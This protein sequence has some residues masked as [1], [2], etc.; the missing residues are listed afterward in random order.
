MQ[1]SSF[2]WHGSSC[3]ILKCL[4]FYYCLHNFEMYDFFQS[5]VFLMQ[6]SKLVLPKTLLPTK[7]F[8]NITG[9][10]QPISFK[11]QLV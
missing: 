10:H 11:P 5:K 4:C 6:Q 1:G 9:I 2:S 3:S 7:Y 8:V